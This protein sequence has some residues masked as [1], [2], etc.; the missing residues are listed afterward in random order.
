L[1]AALK[2]QAGQNEHHGFVDPS[3]NQ[4]DLRFG[5]MLMMWKTEYRAFC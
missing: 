4:K 3:S 2:K 1:I 5:V